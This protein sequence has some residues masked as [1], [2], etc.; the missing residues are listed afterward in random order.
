MVTGQ[1]SP[2]DNH[3]AIEQQT[4]ETSTMYVIG[5]VHGEYRS[6]VLLLREAGLIDYQLNWTAGAATLCFMG[7]YVDRGPDGI[8]VID[9]VMSLQK[10]AEAEGG[11]VIALLGNHDAFLLAVYHFGDERTERRSLFRVDWLTI[12]GQIR[13]LERM[14]PE[15]ARWLQELP[16]M[17]LVNDRLLI[18]ADAM[19]YTNYGGSIAEVND[20]IAGILAGDEMEDWHRL[21]DDFIER[22]AFTLNNY[23]SNGKTGEAQA[24]EL[25]EQFGGQQIIHGHSPIS[26]MRDIPPG[27]VTSAFLYARGLCV[28][29]DGG[30]YRGSPG[31]VYKV[32]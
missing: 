32:E 18:H 17:V 9:L 5:D 10:Q 3:K 27:M 15:H 28:N 20:R 7:D 26:I 4:D 19:M 23:R 31:F 22:Y 2:V 25:L 6:L 12:G 14:T 29:V 11:E 13:D 8:E 16:A 1:A 24:R 30:M 21:L